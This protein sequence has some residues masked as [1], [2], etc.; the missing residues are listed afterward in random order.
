[1]TNHDEL[2]KM[3]LTHNPSVDKHRIAVTVK[4]EAPGDRFTIRFKDKFLPCERG[5]EH[6]ERRFRQMKICDQSVDNF[7]TI[8]GVDKYISISAAGGYLP[9]LLRRILKC[10][11]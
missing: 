4:S 10:P 5:N 7:K 1:M 9:E 11:R 8:A 3:F 2:Q 6:Q